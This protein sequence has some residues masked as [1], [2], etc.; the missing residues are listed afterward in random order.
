MKKVILL[1]AAI[2]MASTGLWA[3]ET[4]KYIDAD[5][6]EKTVNAIEVVEEANA[7]T[8]GT[9]NTTTW[10]VVTNDV[11]LYQGAICV[12]NVNLILADDKKL[13]ATAV[14]QAAI[15]V[16]GE[17]NSLTIYGQVNQTGQL[18]AICEFG[19]AGIGGGSG[20]GSNITINGGMITAKD[21]ENNASAIGNGSGAKTPAS[22]IKVSTK[23]IVKAG[24]DEE[25]AEAIATTRSDDT[26]IASELKEKHYVSIKSIRTATCTYIDENGES[27]EVVATEV[28]SS[29]TP[30]TWNGGWYV[31]DDANVLHK[32]AICQ[33][34]V[35]LILADGAKLTTTGYWNDDEKMGYA[36]IQVSG[37]GNSLNIYGQAA[38]TGQLEANGGDGAAGIGGKMGD[39][40][41]NITI[42]GG[43]VT[44][45]A[46]DA[47]GI[48]GG[49][50]GAGFNIII[51][52]GN[53][54]ANSKNGAGIGGGRLGNGYNITINGGMVT[55]NSKNGAGIGGGEMGSGSD[56]R[57]ATTLLVKADNNNPPTEEIEHDGGCD[58][59]EKLK[60]RRYVTT[61][62]IL[63]FRNAAIATIYAV[64][65][66]YNN[67]IIKA[68]AETAKTDIEA[69]TTTNAINSIKEKA[70]A[71]L[72]YALALY[73]AGKTEVL[74]SLGEKQTGPAIE[75]TDQN[76]N[77]VIL[78]NPKKVNFIKVE[79]E[80]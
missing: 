43:V 27:Q 19:G 26:D 63:P 4:V 16:S 55:A 70:L 36:G 47:A 10:Y 67:E 57:V 56:I 32:G 74:G 52:R 78:Y 72:Q 18:E 31:V 37:E 22:N 28:E 17:G 9:A 15:Q 76:D 65:K 68:I 13:S 51:N 50:R 11:T 73:D 71:D 20:P 24:T 34:D 3:Q 29:Y 48:G 14:G 75:V 12:G 21:N 58:I 2:M 6:Q 33:G 62:S 7:V 49:D 35:R 40:G 1:F 61:D 79:T 39:A 53:V 25:H 64:G 38:Q 30:V 42:N 23:L 60:G 41:S 46:S 8:W 44:A 66:D 5:G 59:A 45:N 54:T 80:E 69:A 77:S